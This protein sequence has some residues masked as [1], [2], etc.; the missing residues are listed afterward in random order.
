MRKIMIATLLAA[1]TGVVLAVTIH[2]M[3]NLPIKQADCS[4]KLIV[5]KTDGTC[6]CKKGYVWDDA[7]SK[8]A[9]GSL[10]C[11]K[12]YAKKSVYVSADNECA[13][14][15]GFELSSKGGACA[16][17][18]PVKSESPSAN[19]LAPESTALPTET[20]GTEVTLDD[21]NVADG[22][23]QLDFESGLRTSRGYPD[24]MIGGIL[25]NG[26]MNPTMAGNFI[27][28]KQPFDQVRE[29]PETGYI[30]TGVTGATN[31]KVY[32]IK[33]VEGNYAKFEVLDAR[34]DTV[35]KLRLFKLKYILQWNGVRTMP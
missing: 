34:Y 19:E 35:K 26:K 30:G 15:K 8:C 13:C 9:K 25:S 4:A 29:C 21:S 6:E 16:K 23:A 10:W 2:A 31:G 3:G 17:S 27:E 5:K 14:R 1:F 12:N 33:T 24:M 18:K 22:S 7:K 20:S 11:Q 32:C 28:M